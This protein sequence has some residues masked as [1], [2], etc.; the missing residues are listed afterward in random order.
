MYRALQ[1]FVARS[2]LN[3][4]SGNF[5]A[6]QVQNRKDSAVPHRIEEVDGLPASFERTGLGFSVADD[7]GDDQ[8]RIIESGSERVNQRIAEFPAFVHGIRD[9][10]S[11]MAGHAARRRELPEKKPQAVLIWRDLR[12]NFGIRAFQIGVRIERGTAMS[13]DR[14]CK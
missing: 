2:S 9:V 4:R 1:V 14:R 3:G 13:R 8:I 5:V 6:V 11:A 10:R 7:A 12:M